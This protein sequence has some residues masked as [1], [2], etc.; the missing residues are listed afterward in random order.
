MK[1]K[2]QC[3]QNKNALSP[4][5]QC[6]LHYL[7]DLHAFAGHCATCIARTNRQRGSSNYLLVVPNHLV[8]ISSYLPFSWSFLRASFTLFKSSSFF[9]ATAMP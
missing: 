2:H 3:Q 5:Q 9:L 8:K 4:K 7:C 6:I 1:P